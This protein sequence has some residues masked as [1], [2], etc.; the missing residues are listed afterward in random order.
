MGIDMLKLLLIPYVRMRKP[1]AILREYRLMLDQSPEAFAKRLGIA[2]STLRS[3]ENGTRRITPERAVEIEKALNGAI[4]R[5]R[6]LPEV[7]GRQAA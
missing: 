5:E 2:E 3:L 7:F 4:P 6:L 1:Y